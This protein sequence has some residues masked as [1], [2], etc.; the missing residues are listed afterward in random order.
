MKKVL[1]SRWP[2]SIEKESDN[3]S[4][5]L[6]SSFIP[7][8]LLV[9][10]MAWSGADS[11][12]SVSL[13][14]KRHHSHIQRWASSLICASRAVQVGSCSNF[15]SVVVR[16]YRDR[17]QT[18]GERNDFSPQFRV[19][20]HCFYGSQDRSL[21]SFVSHPCQEQRD[22]NTCMLISYFRL[23]ITTLTHSGLAA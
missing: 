22:V 16:K 1:V 2:G 13:P 19:T 8:G 10:G 12:L 21:D 6:P 17:K 15:I 9:F 18:M 4:S 5:L 20:V 3:A 23:D 11:C 14:W 7:P